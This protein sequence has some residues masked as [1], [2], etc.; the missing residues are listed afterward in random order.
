MYVDRKK[1]R[2]PWAILLFGL[3]LA[4]VV[5]WRV[6]VPASGQD[7]EEESIAAMRAAVERSARQCYVVEGAYPPS[8]TYLEENYGLQINSEDFYIVYDI[9]ASNIPPAVRVVRR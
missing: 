4:L 2:W 7:M 3:L 9:F 1:R 5:L 6:R 8:L